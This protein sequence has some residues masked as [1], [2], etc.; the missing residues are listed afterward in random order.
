M[1]NSTTLQT[2]SLDSSSLDE[3]KSR[4]KKLIFERSRKR[5]DLSRIRCQKIKIEPIP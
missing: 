5:V 3:L 1:E 4:T 2:I